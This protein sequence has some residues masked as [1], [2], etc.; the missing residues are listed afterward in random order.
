MS[1]KPGAILLVDEDAAQQGLITATLARAGW[2]I[3]A[4][5][6]CEMAL[7]RLADADAIPIAAVLIDHAMPDRAGPALVAAIRVAHPALPIVLLAAQGV[8]AALR[9]GATDVLAK[10]VYADQLLTALDTATSGASQ[11][12]ASAEA[13]AGVTL[14][15]PNGHLR[16]LDEIEGDIIRLAI[17]HYRG[18]MT[19]VARRLRIGRSTL[20]RKLEE[21]G[22]DRA[23]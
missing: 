23:A 2:T 8:V 15:K 7:A 12:P 16:P 17:D 5:R 20:Y 10:P 21:L 19:E 4:A 1:S 22:I 9:A 13:I 14:F 3:V 6:D 18:R 11:A